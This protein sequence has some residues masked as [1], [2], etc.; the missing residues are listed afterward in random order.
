MT[1]DTLLVVLALWGVGY[2]ACSWLASIGRQSAPSLGREIVLL[3]LWWAIIF[4]I[5]LRMLAYGLG[6]RGRW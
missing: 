6:P 3:L 2:I 5:L 4:V 1:G